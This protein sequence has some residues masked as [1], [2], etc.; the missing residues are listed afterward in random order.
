MI[1]S[2]KSHHRKRKHRKNEKMV[3]NSEKSKKLFIIAS[4]NLFII[5]PTVL[6]KYLYYK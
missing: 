2:N 6:E 4:V 3:L 1:K 5:I